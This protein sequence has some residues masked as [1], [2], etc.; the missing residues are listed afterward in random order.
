MHIIIAMDLKQLPPATNLPIFLTRPDVQQAFRFMTL[1]ENR[2]VVDGGVGRALELQNYHDVLTDVSLGQVTDRVRNF[3]IEKFCE[4]AGMTGD[5]E[6]FEGSNCICAK[7]RYRDRFN[8]KVVRRLGKDRHRLNIKGKCRPRDARGKYMADKG[9]LEEGAESLIKKRVKPKALWALPLAG[10]WDID[11]LGRKKH[12]MPVMLTQ[13]VDIPN[14]FANGTQGSIT[15]WYPQSV[16]TRKRSM[17]TVPVDVPG[18]IYATFV[19]N[20][21]LVG[22]KQIWFPGVDTMEL[23]PLPEYLPGQWRDYVL[24]QFPCIPAWALTIHKCQ[25]LTMDGLV[26][27]LLG[28]IFAHGSTLRSQRPSIRSAH[29]CLSSCRRFS[30]FP[31][32]PLQSEQDVITYAVAPMPWMLAIPPNAGYIHWLFKGNRSSEPEVHRPSAERHFARRGAPSA[33]SRL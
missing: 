33:C 25:S 18:G 31:V 4:G 28:G 3:F 30:T 2:R 29:C 13:N 14:G 27:L 22:G 11:Q 5:N 20:K 23:K 12:Y 6:P 7:R 9:W 24:E 1:R 10:D 26:K 15:R 19:K 32:S 8:R 16:G 17:Y 21:S